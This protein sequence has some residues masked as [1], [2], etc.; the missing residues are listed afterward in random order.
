[1][2]TPMKTTSRRR[3]GKVLAALTAAVGPAAAAQQKPQE[4]Q[5]EADAKEEPPPPC[6][7]NPGLAEY[8][9]PRDTEPSFT[10]KA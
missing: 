6:S 5:A 3:F 7:V 4:K 10:F 2:K 8:D 1:M 9:I